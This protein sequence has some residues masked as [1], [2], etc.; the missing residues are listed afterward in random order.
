MNSQEIPGASRKVDPLHDH[1]PAVFDPYGPADH[2][3]HRQD[4]PP[5]VLFDPYFGKLPRDNR[6]LDIVTWVRIR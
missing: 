6:N 5:V 2:T 3:H 4:H 1:S